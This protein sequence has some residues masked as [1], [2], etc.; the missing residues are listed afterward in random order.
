[1]KNFK[2]FIT[3]PRAAIHKQNTGWKARMAWIKDERPEVN[4]WW[5]RYVPKSEQPQKGLQGFR[6]ANA[7][8]QEQKPDRYVELSKLIQGKN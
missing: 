8:K 3:D 5:N 7:P 4:D 6:A 1:M 2:K